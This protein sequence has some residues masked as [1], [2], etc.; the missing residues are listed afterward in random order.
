MEEKER[1]RIKALKYSLARM[2]GVMTEAEL[3]E[4]RP[5]I[6]TEPKLPKGMKIRGLIRPER[7]G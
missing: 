5:Y 7:M 4:A 6:R 1:I 3:R 2:K